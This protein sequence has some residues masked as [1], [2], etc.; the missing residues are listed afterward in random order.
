MRNTYLPGFLLALAFICAHAPGQNAPALP[1][2]ASL[3][4]PATRSSGVW[5]G[6]VTDWHSTEWRM[7]QTHSN[8]YSGQA[9]SQLRSYTE[10]GGG[11]N[12]IDDTG[13]WQRSE[14]TI[15]ISTNLGG[16]AALKGP[17]KVYFSP[18]IGLDGPT[19]RIVS[20]SNVVLQVQP[21]EIDYVDG[22]G[23]SVLLAHIRG[24]APG[25]LVPPNRVVYHSITTNGISCDLVYTYTHGA[26]ESDLL[27]L[28]QP[29][30]TP[31]MLGLDAATARISL[32]HLVTG[33]APKLSPTTT[34]TGLADARMDFGGLTF[35]QGF[36]FAIGGSDGNNAAPPGT[37]TPAQ[38]QMPGSG[39]DGERIPVAKRIIPVSPQQWGLAE[40]VRWLDIQPKLEALPAFT[41]GASLSKP[42][43]D[44]S[45]DE[46]TPGPK[47]TRPMKVA[48]VGYRPKAV[49]LDFISIV[50]GSSFTFASGQTYYLSSGATFSGTVNFFGS[51][52]IKET[53]GAYLYLTGPVN[54]YGNAANPSIITSFNDW[55]FGETNLP[56][57]SGYWTYSGNPAL[58]INYTNSALTLNGLKIRW[59]QTGLE[60]DGNGS[61]LNHTLANSSIEWCSNGVFISGCVVTFSTS[62]KCTLTNAITGTGTWGSSGTLVDECAGYDG[63]LPKSWEFEYFGQSGVNASADPDGDG[64][65]NQQEYTAGTNPFVYDGP[66]IQA[67]PQGQLVVQGNNATFSVGVTGTGTLSYQWYKGGLPILSAT[68]SS[69]TITNVQLT[70]CDYYFVI[71]TNPYGTVSSSAAFLSVATPTN[72][73]PLP[74]GAVAWWPGESNVTDIV[75]T[76]TGYWSNTV[77]YASGEVGHA[78][79]FDGVSSYI[80]VP[81]S[82]GLRLTNVMTIEFWVKR[83]RLNTYDY[84]L[85]K[86]G[87]WTM[88]QQNY[89][90]Q[91]HGPDN[92]LCL[93]WNNGYRIAYGITNMNWHHCAVVATNGAANP[94]FY[95]DGVAQTIWSSYGGAMNL[96]G[97]TRPL[98]IGAEIDPTYQF[99]ANAVIDELTFYT[100]ALSTAQI[101]AIYNA[102]TSGK[103]LPPT[104]PVIT[105][106]PAGGTVNLGGTTNFTVAASGTTPLA[107]QWMVNG[108]AIAG[109]TSSSYTVTNV[110]PAVGDPYYIYSVIVANIGGSTLSSPALLSVSAAYCDGSPP[111]VLDWYRAEGNAKDAVGTNNGTWQGTPAYVN[112]IVNQAFDF[113]GTNYVQIPSSSTL[114][115]SNAITIEFWYKDLG[116]PSWYGLVAKRSTTSPWPCNYGINVFDGGNMQVYYLDPTYGS[117]QILSWPSPSTNAWH[118]IGVTFQQVSGSSVQVQLYIDGS[119]K[120]YSIMGGVLANTFDNSPVTIGASYP[121]GELFNGLIDEVTIYSRVLSSSEI[122]ALYQYGSSW[123]TGKC[124]VP[125]TI[126]FQPQSITAIQGSTVTFA[127]ATEPTGFPYPSMYWPVFSWKFNGNLLTW[128]WANDDELDIT[129]VQ[130]ANAGNYMLIASNFLGATYSDT[131]TLT[132]LTPP[133]II[134]QPA[135]QVAAPQANVTFTVTATGALPMSY[136]WNLD[137]RAIPGATNSSYNIPSVALSSYGYYSVLITNVAGSALSTNAALS[138]TTGCMPAPSGV[139]SWWRGET[140]SLDTM[141]LNNTLFTGGYANGEVGLAFQVTNGANN[142]RIPAST[143]LNVGTG[144]GFTIEGWINNYDST[145]RPVF[146]WGTTTNYAVHVWVNWP[147]S[148]TLYANVI[149]TGGVNHSFQ[150]SASIFT[151]SNLLHVALTYDKTLGTGKLY[152]NGAQV[153]TS[154][155]GGITPQTSYD[156]Y[157]G[158][159]PFSSGTSFNGIIDEAALYSRALGSNEVQAIYSAGAVGKCFSE[160]AG[161]LSVQITT[162]TSIQKFTNVT[163]VPLS[164]TI[165]DNVGSVTNVQFFLD[166]TFLIGTATQSGTNA[167]V[168][169]LTWTTNLAVGYY[170]IVASAR[171]NLGVSNTSPMVVFKVVP[172]NGPPVVFITAPTNGAVFPAGANVTVAATAIG[173]GGVAITNV[174]FFQNTISLGNDI[175]SPFQIDSLGL[176]PGTYTFSAFATDANGVQTMSSN[177]TVTVLPWQ[178]LSLNG[179][180][181]PAFHP[182]HWTTDS[183]DCDCTVTMAFGVSNEVYVAHQQNDSQGYIHFWNSCAWT[184]LLPGQSING[185]KV[186]NYQGP[187]LLAGG[188]NTGGSGFQFVGSYSG[189]SFNDWAYGRLGQEV[190]ALQY[191]KGDLYAGGG[192]SD[193]Q[194][195]DLER[196]A[197]LNSTSWY[198]VGGN[199]LSGGSVRAI[200]AIG[201]DI[202]V[203][204]DFTAAGSDT[205]VA[206]VAKLSGTNWIAL[207][208]GVNGTVK[209][210]AVWNGQLVAGGSFTEAGGNTNISCIAKW[211]GS[212]WSGLGGT[213]NLSG[214]SPTVNAIAVY[215]ND[216]FIGGQFDSVSNA[217]ASFPSGNLAHLQWNPH[218]ASWSWSDL[219]GGVQNDQVGASRV[220]SLAL[221]QTGTNTQELVIG[222]LFDFAGSFPSIHV[223][224]WLIGGNHC[225]N[226]P[227]SIQISSPIWNSTNPPNTSIYI[228]ASASPGY[229]G[230]LSNVTFYADI[231]NF[232]GA[233][234]STNGSFATNWNPGS[235][236]NVHRIDAIASDTDGLA[237]KAT[238]FFSVGSS[239][240]AIIL[241]PAQYVLAA[242]APPTPLY[243]LAN[244]SGATGISS[245]SQAGGAVT[246]AYG[247]TNLVYTPNTN[248]YGTNI[249]W[250]TATN[251]SGAWAQTFVTVTVCALPGIQITNPPTQLVTNLP[252]TLTIAGTNYDAD[253]TISTVQVFTNGSPYA[254]ITP[255]G[256]TFSTNWSPSAPGFYTFLAVATDGYNY[257]G[258]SS[259][260]V[261]QVTT[262]NVNQPFAQITSPTD[263]KTNVGTLAYTM[264]YVVRNGQLTVTG[265]AYSGDP[266]APVWWQIVLIDPSNPTNPPLYNI[267]PGT[268]N[269]EGFATNPVVSGTLA[270]NFDVSLVQNGAYQLTLIVQS[271][272]LQTIVSQMI[273]VESNLKIGQFSFSEQDLVIPVNGIPIT[274][275]RTYNSLN[276]YSRDFGY[277]WT[278]SL[279]SMDVQ[280]DETRQNI[281]L[282]TDAAPGDD[283][284]PLGGNGSTVSVRTGGGWD[285]SL[286]LPDGPRT[287][288][289]FAPRQGTGVAYGQWNA[290]PGVY[291][292]LTPLPSQSTEID[293]WPVA[294]WASGGGGSDMTYDDIPGWVLQTLDGTQYSI[295]RDPGVP[296]G[297]I[298]LQTAPAKFASVRVFGPP[299]LTKIIQRSG[300]IITIGANGISHSI[301]TNQTRSISFVR[302]AFNRIR[303]IFDPNSG[304][305]GLAVLQYVYND[306]GNLIQVQKLV[307]RNAGTYSTNKYWYGNSQFPHYITEIDNAF[308]APITRNTYDSSGR[309]IASMDANGNITQYIHNLTNN[310][311]LVIDPL[312][313]TNTLAYDSRGNVTAV[314]NALGGITLSTYDNANN[315]ISEIVYANGAP[316]ATNTFGFD[317]NTG[318][319]LAST[320]ALGF[321]NGF[322]YNSFGEM[323]TSTDPLNHSSTS[324]YDSNTGNLLGTADALSGTTTN[325]YD[326]NSLLV[327]STDAAGAVTTNQYDSNG[328]LTFS[329]TG[330][331]SNGAFVTMT[332]TGYGYDGDGNRTVTTNG[333]GVVTGY[334]F[335]G[336]NRIVAT[337][338]NV[339]GGA[340]QTVRW[341]IYDAAGR[342]IQTVDARGVTNAFGYDLVGHR[343]S[344]T[345]AL[346]T[347]VAQVMLGS[348]DAAGNRT[349]QIDN[350]G[351][352][353]DFQYDALNR[354]TVTLLPAAT[355]GATRTG[356]TN[357]FDGLDRRT[358]VTN[359]A[360]VGTGFQFD[361]LSRMTVVTNALG[362][363]TQYQF[364]PLSNETNQIDALSHSTKF[365]FDA[366]SR[367]TQ[368]TM[369]GTQAE[370]FGYDAGSRLIAQT[371][372]DGTVITNQ[373]DVLGRLFKRAMI[374]GVVLETYAYSATGQLTNRTD[375]SGTYSWV[376]DNLGRLKTN[377][378]PVG[379]LYYTYDANGNLLT[380]SSATANG[381]S[382]T[383][384]YDALNRLTNVI[385][386]RLTGTKNTGYAF[387][388]AG[389]LQSLSYPIGITNLWQYD[390]LSRLTNLTWKLSGAQRGDFAYQLGAAGNRT[391]LID[392]VNGTSRTFSWGYDNLYRLTNETVSGGSPT[393]TLGYG[394]DDAG[395]RTSRTGTLGS[396]T[397]SNNTFDVNDQVSG[398]VF[399]ANGNTRTNGSIYYGYDWA[400]RLTSQTNGSAVLTI[401]YGADGNRSQR[402]SSGTTTLYLVATVNPSG[403]PQVVEEFTAS[404]GTT[405]LSMVY[406][407]GLALISQ[408]QANGT[409]SF[410]GTDGLGSTRFLTSTN[411]IITDTY[412]Y[413]AFGTVITNTGSTPNNYLFTAQQS[414]PALNLLYLRQRYDI[415]SLGRFLTRDPIEGDDEDPLSLQKFIYCGD[416]PTTAIDPSGR[417]ELTLSGQL[418]VAGGLLT[419][420]TAY[421]T[422]IT[423][424]RTGPVSLPTFDL[425]VSKSTGQQSPK[426]SPKPIPDPVPPIGPPRDDSNEDLLYRGIPRTR[427]DD[428]RRAQ[429]GIA[430]PRGK[431]LDLDA[432]IKHVQN[433]PVD[434]G[435]TS[436]TTRRDVARRFSGSDGIILEVDLFAISDKIVPRPAV[437]RYSDEHEIL[438]KGPIQA[439]PTQPNQP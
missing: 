371:N 116:N 51:C 363:L 109:A 184:S 265:S 399:D 22:S 78:F 48:S 365:A 144:G 20:L 329:R 89:A 278:Y 313:R 347:P 183:N 117:Y 115:L 105:N 241:H 161:S 47:R 242:S 393:G 298:F 386:N 95:I 217:P 203:G 306:S 75:S 125:P 58:R 181:D 170:A 259:P 18:T 167:N 328:N 129:N 401:A 3:S 196:I 361:L 274:V 296:S 214:G 342:L 138:Y 398:L 412:A 139:V 336:Q 316:Y 377:S 434:S 2:P 172:T 415:P 282:G 118:H 287:T 193:F 220:D 36:A 90:L 145:P 213:I 140:N 76:N 177:V 210:L 394:Y 188:Y 400:N 176:L 389:N 178:S 246:I 204:G 232:I 156:L 57:S 165:A 159:R 352:E 245:V 12:Y 98:H 226:N 396:L 148:G 337:T 333:L 268:L 162:P 255:T 309:L 248:N 13:T 35:P 218:T 67:Q 191:I 348:Y 211:D 422:S 54:C 432:L 438:L 206:F 23:T 229:G 369:P 103:Y 146:E 367:R 420:A 157:L 271:E 343:T 375:A 143:S 411:G 33:P 290:E 132:V 406:T 269:A 201:D 81:D 16:A 332:Y 28:S 60:M 397:A 62:Y 314:T 63:S 158:Y 100:N 252:V 46:Q 421:Y 164:A 155:I 423:L 360:G 21:M 273:Q 320:N 64:L 251:A 374:N 88:G 312:G 133:V 96:Y 77:A 136:Q 151:I 351:R 260:V 223:A 199:A 93:T 297:S 72:A 331:Y 85:E 11:I 5:Q 277:S 263:L 258:T 7:S 56:G 266:G 349:N 249:F 147:W 43:K 130:P 240:N 180:W 359:Q 71:V 135:N 91:F 243:V 289:A 113:V 358:G 50:S 153:A 310:L 346:G 9:Q 353:I 120:T 8:A 163:S 275:T 82:P 335:D 29:S 24:D 142:V 149:D 61:G 224:R 127:A 110:Q 267:T 319:L 39:G 219:D 194:T 279:D 392:N 38:V 141:G 378:T 254:T 294:H 236:T 284:D 222:G 73:Y 83:L 437:A 344:M 225:A 10:V 122:T 216:I 341:T 68:S 175:V 238:V 25:E 345:R 99:Y 303:A 94:V 69:F 160:P 428:F 322:I 52:V 325:F 281:Q 228:L 87:D 97:S 380:L 4:N 262:T 37:W 198:P 311:E 86:G 280:L 283:G 40:E 128:P 65:S 150:S 169:N 250:Y 126:V 317:P 315:R 102:G 285:V 385:D 305:N 402:T 409:I 131:A 173:G 66:Q 101:Q 247:A 168:F 239:V 327:S 253:T 182:T 197:R 195:N 362:K 429:L 230:S 299:K 388:G 308:G 354:Q 404:G 405:N 119:Y 209:A 355:S 350:I 414:D 227:P 212:S 70:N 288:F 292:T 92:G 166:K 416:S 300:D 74:S 53:N 154:A 192:F 373:Y 27:I 430:L 134:V 19:I 256:G 387:D 207:G 413:D 244:A 187:T 301:G 307:D 231:T 395:N 237:T 370:K 435:V 418:M 121:G 431:R 1:D 174:Q 427:I 356:I 185:I 372:F 152:L 276:P 104:A 379:T 84:L 111:N 407:Y 189:S 424:N 34:P 171:D 366:L 190:D 124:F 59:A 233:V 123:G 384:Q 381:V 200:A 368:R 291:A 44:A 321:T 42:L 382:L 15:E 32:V 26:F 114:Q 137:G 208:S 403:Y 205:N 383:Y 107:Y 80:Q 270:T 79:Q 426:E 425:P 106:Q 286:N 330:Y 304:T 390:G 186:L 410:F 436:W 295:T 408:R 324:F 234:V 338:N 235:V 326:T 31:G 108:N 112:G 293:F 334:L 419:I 357:I 391:N 272:G 323:V 30:K 215:G 433:Q 202:Y 14:D 439:R 264:P 257:S 41:Q 261:V 221:R 179:R 339:Y 318:L 364:D 6:T 417:A 376:Y 45:L 55:G 340:D 302:D 17:T 49:D